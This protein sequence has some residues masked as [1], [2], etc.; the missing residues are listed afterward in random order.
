METVLAPF[1]I[2][3]KTLDI[4]RMT[5]KTTDQS[6]AACSTWEKKI[7][8]LAIKIRIFYLTCLLLRRP[9]RIWHTYQALIRLRKNVWGGDMKKMYKIDG[10][11]YFNM[12]TPGWPSK[13]YDHIV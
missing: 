3:T 7:V 6:T 4:I 11:Y 12:Y 2:N 9:G 1:G 13:A 10:R 5:D 8:W